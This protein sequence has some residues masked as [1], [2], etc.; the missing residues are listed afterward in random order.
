MNSSLVTPIQFVLSLSLFPRIL[1]IE[2]ASILFLV[3]FQK[4]CGM[5]LFS[6]NSLKVYFIFLISECTLSPYIEYKLLEDIDHI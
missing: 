4:Y 5:Y 1:F 6:N 2:L 3:L